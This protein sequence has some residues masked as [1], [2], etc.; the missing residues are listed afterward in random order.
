MNDKHRSGLFKDNYQFVS[1]L[2]L[3]D[4]DIQYLNIIPIGLT[5]YQLL[6]A[7]KTTA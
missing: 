3:G 5:S 7:S 6:V 1:C 4:K 2:V